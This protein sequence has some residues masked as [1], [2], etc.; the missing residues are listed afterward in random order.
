MKDIME[1]KDWTVELRVCF[2]APSALLSNTSLCRLL[3]AL[4]RVQ[5]QINAPLY[6]QLW[7]DYHYVSTCGAQGCGQPQ[8]YGYLPNQ[9]KYAGNGHG[10]RQSFR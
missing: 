4:P 8:L 3:M 1:A 2:L 5:V 7:H 10:H 6:A 9:Q